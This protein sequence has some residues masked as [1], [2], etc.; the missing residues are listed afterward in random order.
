MGSKPKVEAP[1]YEQLADTDYIKGLRED[2][3]TYRDQYNYLLGQLDVTSPEVQQKFQDIAN[4]YTASQWSD[5]NRNAARQMKALNAANY[6]RFGNL[7]S[8]GAQYTSDTFGRNL[9]D[10]ATRI[11]GQTAGQY[12]NLINN[13]YNQK[14]GTAQMYGGAYSNAGNVVQGNDINNWQIRNKN[15]EAKYVADLQ[16]AQNSGG[17]SLGN[18]ISGAA[19][20]ALG[21]AKVG[22]GWGALA[23]GVLG[24][25][26][27]G[28]SGYSNMDGQQAGQLGASLGNIGGNTT[29]WLNSKIKGTNWTWK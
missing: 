28:L 7:G 10:L 20:G 14:L 11:A 1:V 19:S 18:M 3:P 29:G 5:Y 8:S 4:D 13:Y 12:Q 27:G 2:L 16:N 17:W 23:G 24:A 9:N 15:I 25:V 26:G 21:G 6:G 22:G